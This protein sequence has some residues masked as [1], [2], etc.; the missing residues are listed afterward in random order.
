MQIINESEIGFSRKIKEVKFGFW[1]LSP[2]EQTISDG[3]VTRELEPLLY[4]MLCYFITHHDRIISRQE[5]IDNVWQQ[6]Y[7]DDNAIN[8]AISELRKALKSEKQRG[9]ILKTHYRKGYSF[10]PE[11]E[12]LY[13]PQKTQP[14]ADQPVEN[15][16]S[17]AQVSEQEAQM[18]GQDDTPP[19]DTEAPVA[20]SSNKVKYL[21]T[22]GFILILLMLVFSANWLYQSS[23]IADKA[24]DL[25]S[26]TYSQEILSWEK[27]TVT[28]P[29]LS[30]NKQLLAYSFTPLNSRKS[31][32]HIKNMVTL[33]EYKIAEGEANI[34]PVGWS[35]KN[36]L[37]YQIVNEE[38][39]CELWQVNLSGE[40]AE[41]QH[42]KLFNCSFGNIIT[43]DSTGNKLL[44]TKYNYRNKTGLSAIV[45][46]DL[47]TGN[48][49]QVTSPNIGE[50]G[51][52][53][54]K[55]SNNQDKILFLRMQAKGT[56]I[57]IADIDGS[58]QTLLFD[59]DYYIGAINWDKADSSIVWLN[60]RHKKLLSYDLSSQK[61]VEES[62]DTSHKLGRLFATDL[63]QRERLL[64][65]TSFDDYNIAT[66]D[67]ESETPVLSDYSSTSALERHV[68]PYN[69]SEGSIYVVEQDVN[70]IWSYKDGI[71]KKIMD[72][73]D[74]VSN[75]RN[76]DLSPDDKQL[77]IVWKNR[78]V[79]YQL[80]DFSLQQDIKLDG[81]IKSAA[82]PLASDI[83]LTY[84]E[85][86]KTNAWFYN[87]ESGNLKKL[88][89][90]QIDLALLVTDKDLLFIDDLHRLIKKN[91][92][93]G[94]TETLMTFSQSRPF[95]WTA[96]K[97]NIYYAFDSKLIYKKPL[98]NERPAEKL[99]SLE[100]GDIRDLTIKRNQSQSLLYLTFW[101]FKSNYLLDLTLKENQ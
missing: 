74:N 57:F 54:V 99:L 7:V 47:G 82:W 62:I 43:A 6:A 63:I 76:L 51:D 56:Q 86:L 67:L 15:S 59:L 95:K 23:S 96:D 27:G 49:F 14:A 29:K 37:F 12:V 78:L 26:L 98:N 84:T 60:H 83:L 90:S 65:T 38:N 8:R 72:L 58:N 73:P 24:D 18:A 87:I 33:K 97:E 35:E 19:R 40:I 46:R 71:R 77:L 89:N 32:L 85:A 36:D 5:L 79:I 2:K 70:S 20:T 17:P 28:L 64:F 100:V 39:N 48:E 75:L 50:M 13:H 16:T 69:H 21:S 61:V 91:I 3:E 42:K 80:S 11:I 44:Y 93:S 55:I 10:L 94:D 9:H 22:G 53:F 25:A 34:L 30:K 68:T 1:S 41:A 81:I 52:Y 31:N 4:S 101:Q 66:V 45:S 92:T 88:T